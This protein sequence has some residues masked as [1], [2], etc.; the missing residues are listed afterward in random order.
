MLAVGLY[1]NIELALIGRERNKHNQ[2]IS[3][4]GEYSREAYFEYLDQLRVQEG[5]STWVYVRSEPK[6][7]R[8]KEGYKFQYGIQ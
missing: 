6:Y 3:L 7:E 1:I 8:D 2:K 4:G 5:F